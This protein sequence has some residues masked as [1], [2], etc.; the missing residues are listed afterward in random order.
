M[1]CQRHLRSSL[2]LLFSGR[3]VHDR[4]GLRLEVLSP[5]L[6]LDLPLA[7]IDD[8]QQDFGPI[9]ERAGIALF[10]KIV[11]LVYYNVLKILIKYL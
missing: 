11:R 9:F 5:A 10:H 4:A 8:F 1:P 3:P 6:K 7:R 2:F